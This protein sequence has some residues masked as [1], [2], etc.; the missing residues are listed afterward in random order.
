MSTLT[1]SVATSTYFVK[2]KKR[3]AK[4]A[5]L[6]ERWFTSK[7]WR[8]HSVL[9]SFLNCYFHPL[10]IILLDLV[11][12]STVLRPG[13]PRMQPVQLWPLPPASPWQRFPQL[14]SFL[15]PLFIHSHAHSPSAALQNYQQDIVS[16]TATGSKDLSRCASNPPEQN[17]LFDNSAWPQ[18]SSRRA[19]NKSG[20]DGRQH[21]WFRHK[22]H[23]WVFSTTKSIT[24]NTRNQHWQ[25]RWAIMFQMWWVYFILLWCKTKDSTAAQRPI[26]Y[27]VMEKWCGTCRTWWTTGGSG[28]LLCNMTLHC[29]WATYWK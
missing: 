2:K 26:Y 20:G 25:V 8:H 28:H 24:P 9:I 6:W 1:E 17:A 4:G 22:S 12:T 19:V 15:C 29:R 14:Y 10:A 18:K 21:R 11:I 27:K 3:F 13:G 16:H 23:R 5:L 7:P